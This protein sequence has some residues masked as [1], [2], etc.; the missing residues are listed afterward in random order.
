MATEN[1]LSVFAQSVYDVVRSVPRGKVVSYADVAQALGMRSA[2]AV[3]QA[4]RRNP[5]APE[6]PCHRVVTSDGGLGGFWGG[7]DEVRLRQK[8]SLLSS[9]RVAVAHGRIDMTL[10][11]HSL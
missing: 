6:V 10:F 1:K 7:A 2:R 8:E 3:G 9:E 11:R 5:F 4:L